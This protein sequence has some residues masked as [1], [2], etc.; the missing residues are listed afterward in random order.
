MIHHLKG[1]LIEKNPTYIVIACNGVGY[2]VNISLHTFS[3]IPDSENISIY[4]HLHVKEDSHTLY[5]F[6]QK[7]ERDIFRLLISVSGVGTSTART[8][9]S[10][11]EPNQVKD[12]IANG[13]VP[14]IQSVKGIGAKTAQRVILDLKDK[15]LKVYGEDEVF[16]PQDNTIKE[17]ALSAL[18]TLG[19]ARKQA[20][21]VVDKIMK[22]S[23]SPTV[24]SIIK[25]A[26]K[27]L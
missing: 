21:R 15:I 4:T 7:S 12:A 24:E 26:L 1:Q 18:E 10:S 19:F 16:V 2:M 3:L 13:D 6:Y 14:T 9:L 27:N 22:D 25:M 23:N 5:G 17:E 8:M 20:T 11:L